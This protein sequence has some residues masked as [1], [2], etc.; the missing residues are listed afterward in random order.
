MTIAIFGN[1]QK[2][3]T[4]AEVS[5]ILGFMAQKGVNVL[6][7]QELR[8][9]LNLRDYPPFPEDGQSAD[10]TT[11]PYN[12]AIDFAMSIGETALSSPPQQRLGQRISLSSV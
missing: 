5:H 4:L 6:L 9:E 2:E 10:D 12:E 11:N 1:A 7:S 8:Q 3:N